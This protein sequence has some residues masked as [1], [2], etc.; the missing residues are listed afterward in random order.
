MIHTKCC[1]SNMTRRVSKNIALLTQNSRSAAF[2]PFRG[3]RAQRWILCEQSDFANFEVLSGPEK[4]IFHEISSS[5]TCHGCTHA[6]LDPAQT[7]SIS[8][9]SSWGFACAKLI[10]QRQLEKYSWRK[11]IGHFMRNL[12]F[13]TE[14]LHIVCTSLA[15]QHAQCH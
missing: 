4:S 2:A 8:Y 11:R 1:I 3:G 12:H 6:N 9:G 10:H 15:T 13:S 7:F 14:I 5:D